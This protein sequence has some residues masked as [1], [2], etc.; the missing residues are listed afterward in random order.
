MK[1]HILKTR[2]QELGY[3][4]CGGGWKFVDM[5]TGAD[6]G[7]FYQAKQELLADIERFYSSRFLPVE[8]EKKTTVTHTPGPIAA[9]PD[10][11]ETCKMALDIMER[12]GPPK[13]QKG[14]LCE[15]QDFQTTIREL[16]IAIAKAKGEA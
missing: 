10:L 9:A 6:I 3:N 12:I 4:K 8:I 16:R 5:E 1:I 15:E 14:T 13:I 2:Y 11:L 7:P